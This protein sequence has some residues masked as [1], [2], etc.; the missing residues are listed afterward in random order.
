MER[1]VTWTELLTYI[2]DNHSKELFE[3][4]IENEIEKKKENDELE[5]A[6]KMYGLPRQ[7]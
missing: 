3:D 4:F 5:K 1:T 7:K 2:I 6:T